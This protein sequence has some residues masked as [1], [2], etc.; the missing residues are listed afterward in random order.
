MVKHSNEF[1]SIISAR[2]Y[3]RCRD[4]TTIVFEDRFDPSSPSHI[5]PEVVI[6]YRGHAPR[7]NRRG[8]LRDPGSESV[9]LGIHGQTQELYRR[10]LHDHIQTSN[11]III[12]E[13]YDSNSYQSYIESMR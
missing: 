6:N 9:A 4:S 12:E 5:I 7:Y 8:R 1:Y 2:R 13:D 3:L 11:G 10:L